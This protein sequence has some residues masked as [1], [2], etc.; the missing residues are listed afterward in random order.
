MIYR[1]CIYKSIFEKVLEK[2][3]PSKHRFFFISTAEFNANLLNFTSIN[4]YFIFKP[5]ESI[6]KQ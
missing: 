4:F 5:I 2:L 6:L 3:F 1:C